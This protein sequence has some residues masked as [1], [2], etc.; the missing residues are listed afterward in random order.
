M[1]RYY[2]II[3]C[4]VFRYKYGTVN[5]AETEKAEHPNAHVYYD[6]VPE[7]LTPPKGL[8]V[9]KW[10]FLTSISPLSDDAHRAYKQGRSADK[11]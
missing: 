9:A 7:E 6:E 1:F 8:A 2:I 3:L 10:V 4:C 5:A 11:S